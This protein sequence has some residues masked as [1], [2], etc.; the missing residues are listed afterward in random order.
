REVVIESNREF[1]NL[2]NIQ[3]HINEKDREWISV[4]KG[5]ITP[6]MQE[7]MNNE[8]SMELKEIV[9]FH[10]EK[11]G[12]MVF[13]EIFV[14]NK[15]GVNVGQTGKTTDY[16]QADEEWWQNA[17]EN[18][19][20]VENLEYDR[21]AGLYSI[22]IETRIDDEDGN[23]EGILKAVLNVREIIDIIKELESTEEYE[24]YGHEGHK[25]MEFKLFTEDGKIIYSTEEFEL[26]ED[27]PDKLFS[28]FSGRG[29]EHVQYFIGYELG[30]AEELFAHVHS[31]G[32]KDYKGLGWLL[33]VEHE[34]EEVFAPV[35][36]LANTMIIVTAVVAIFGIL[37]S[38]LISRSFTRPIIKLRDAASEIGKGKLDTKIDVETSDEVGQLAS[39]FNQMTIDL[40]QFQ[41]GIKRHAEE[42]EEK[43]K[44]RTE[45]LDTKVKELTDA[46]DAVLNMMEDMNESHKELVETGKELEKSLKELQE[47]DIKKNQ[48]ISIA[49]HELKTPLAS[50][51]SF[52]QLLQDKEILGDFTKSRKYLK[53]MYH[54]NK[55]LAKLVNDILDLSRIDL[56]TIKL[57]FEKVDV[58]ELVENV[59]SEMGIPIKEK[60]LKSEYHVEK[61]MPRVVTD[62]EKLIEILINLISNAV[63]YTNEGKITVRVFRDRGNVHFVVKDTGIGIAKEKQEMI[64]ERFYQI[65]SSFTRKAGGTGLGLALCREFLDMLGG[66]IWVESEPGKGS[67]FHFTLPVKGVPKKQIR[68]GERRAKERIKKAEEMR[69]TL[70]KTGIGK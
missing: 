18:G 64:F 58:N 34:T 47:M 21:S 33:V 14:T 45:D 16:Y 69:E 61:G 26:F 12:Y 10:E 57:N 11:Y 6:F 39:A 7:L 27:A 24:R 60:G 23:F 62:S 56:G 29:G 36:G 59:K 31:E 3:D 22:D 52:S 38:I 54:E 51:I 50:I 4:P 40:K 13:G 30:E 49:A 20:N 63:K 37:L 25:T 32:Y 66:D 43:V 5:T 55:R 48:F 44:E 70:K 15:H 17:K 46:K 8:L 19:L 2:D 53:I 9:D 28:R 65:D 35:V 1:E 67:E 68:G 42:L 41:K